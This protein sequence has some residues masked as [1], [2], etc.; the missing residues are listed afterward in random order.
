MTP[1]QNQPVPVQQQGQNLVNGQPNMAAQFPHHGNRPM[2]QVDM[3]ALQVLNTFY[4]TRAQ[5]LVPDTMAQQQAGM[6]APPRQGVNSA[7]VS[8][9]QQAPGTMAQPP[10]GMAAPHGKSVNFIN[11]IVQQEVPSTMVPLQAGIAP[12]YQHGTHLPPSQGLQFSPQQH[13]RMVQIK[14]ERMKEAQLL[15]QNVMAKVNQKVAEVNQK[16]EM[17]HQKIEEVCQEN[18]QLRQ[19]MQSFKRRTERRMC[20]RIKGVEKRAVERITH[21]VQQKIN[22]WLQSSEAVRSPGLQAEIK[23]LTS[24]LSKAER[25][26]QDL[27]GWAVLGRRFLYEVF[28]SEPQG[29]VEEES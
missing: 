13:A 6:A 14:E 7:N 12:Q 18:K 29:Y 20:N 8:G 25:R 4:A 17:L 23:E 11:G 5:Q 22:L 16:N 15:E 24:A 2:T 9:A 26:I 27:E 28:F 1:F 3:T 19:G 21:D 10:T